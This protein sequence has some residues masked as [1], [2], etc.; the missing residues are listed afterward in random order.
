[1][2]AIQTILD[3]VH[4]HPH[5]TGLI[6]FVVAMAE[7]LVVLGIV[8][9]GA[10]LMLAFG[11]LIEI[12]NLKFWPTV[13]WA[14]AGAVVG[15]G[16]SFF[17]GRYFR[18]SLVGIWPF[19]SHPQWIEGGRAYF[20]R[21]GGKS[22]LLGR[23]VGPLRATVPAVAGMLGMSP[24][25]FLGYNLG[26]ALLWAPAYLLP[27]MVF[28]A[29]LEIAAQVAWRLA[30][31]ALLLLA[32]L[33]TSAWLAVQ[34][35]QWLAPHMESWLNRLTAWSHRHP[36]LGRLGDALVVPGHAEAP[37]LMTAASLLLA[38]TLLTPALIGPR[39]E[40]SLPN[41][42]ASLRSPWG[43]QIMLLIGAIGAW[44]A[45]T[46]LAV[47]VLA[48]LLTARAVGAARHWL[49]AIVFGA[50]LSAAHAWLTA[51]APGQTSDLLLAS[52]QAALA[53]VSF[54]FLATLLAG[55]A[56]PARRPIHYGMAAMAIILVTLAA[57]YLG[58]H[59]PADSLLGGLLGLTWAA[60]VGVAYRRRRQRPLPVA[61]LE[62][63]VALVLVSTVTGYAVLGMP[64]DLA[65]VSESPPSVTIA[66]DQWW[67]SAGAMLPTQRV[68]LPGTAS[69][70]LT[71]QWAGHLPEIERQLH[72]AGWHRPPP[73]GLEAIL[74]WLKPDASA[75]ALPLLPKAHGGHHEALAMVRTEPDQATRLV[76][77]LWRSDFVLESRLP[78]WVGALERQQPRK[79]LLGLLTGS[80]SHPVPPERLIASLPAAT[81]FESKLGD[82]SPRLLLRM[83]TAGPR[84][85]PGSEG[86]GAYCP[87]S[88]VASS[89]LPSQTVFHEQG[90][91]GF[92]DCAERRGDAVG[93]AIPKVRLPVAAFDSHSRREPGK[94][95]Q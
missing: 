31:L 36:L 27:G 18:E 37:A 50:L 76:L 91:M 19:R 82:D 89:Y 29:S 56:A 80:R 9:P 3:W 72:A 95:R 58:T 81:P 59:W 48:V 43:D 21:H 70:P 94:R 1:M 40:D 63:A 85:A 52:P 10:A 55:E 88:A 90:A 47:V 39:G 7:S 33:W 77:R 86:L 12:G 92:A 35:W 14:V 38:A 13:A 44:P 22:V 42:M 15:D 25:R 6:V 17:V 64:R 20:Q 54:G 60:V 83:G 75:A 2:E 5:L 66:T 65:R 46:L 30:V 57:L 51:P 84:A 34:L 32:V 28:A 53:G 69:V 16:L 23:F 61:R 45:Q 41:L 79:L 93:K 87:G 71:V 49:A 73:L 8:I 68:D 74:L 67:S 62:I 78:I 4:A 26:S 11:A 24:L